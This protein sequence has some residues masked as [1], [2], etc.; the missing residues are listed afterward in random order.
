MR[1]V[2]GERRGRGISLLPSGRRGDRDA[3]ACPFAPFTG[4]RRTGLRRDPRLT[5]GG[6]VGVVINGILAT[7][8]KIS[9][10]S[11]IGSLMIP[12]GPYGNGVKPIAREVDAVE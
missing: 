11:N 5:P 4:V 8:P 3:A 6:G 12:V 2:S 1:E 10:R 7:D 9:G